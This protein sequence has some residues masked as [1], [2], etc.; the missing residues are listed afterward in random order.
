MATEK[1]IIKF[2]IVG[3]MG[4]IVN[5]ALLFIFTDYLGIF[6]MFSAVISIEIA[7][8]HNFLWNEFWTFADRIK[9]GNLLGRLARYN[10]LAIGG[11]IIGLVVL[12]LFTSVFGVY[13]LLSNLIGVF[14]AFL[15]N[16]FTNKK[17]TWKD[18]KGIGEGELSLPKDPML[19]IIIPTYNERENIGLIVP[20]I[21]ASLP[22]K[23]MRME[24]IVVDDGSPDGTAKLARDLG[25]RYNVRVIER[26]G[27]RGL[28]PAVLEG[29]GEA[30]GDILGVMDADLSHPP[31]A[32]P[33]LIEPI[34]KRGTDLV[35][36]SRR[37]KGGKTEGWSLKR[38]II[39]WGAGFLSMGLTSVKD[40]MSGFFFLKKGVIRSAVLSPRGFKIGLEI[41]VKGHY[42][43][44]EEI[45]YKF[46]DRR[47]GKSKLGIGE[48]LSYLRH[49]IGLYWYRIN[50]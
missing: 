46:T 34:L 13:Y 28:S 12:F 50:R 41:I 23:W 40:P 2:M 5:E 26:K 33:R 19:S 6:Y 15:W 1:R 4:T 43:S 21:F 22:R 49:L 38:K 31:E 44:I 35:I 36:G 20:K 30:R 8:V 17:Y 7:L 45:P 11:M 14:V 42:R 48:D 37:I 9:K 27:K 16:Y 24:V 47:F 18:S 39:S 29:L 25:K 3:A 10:F 32:I